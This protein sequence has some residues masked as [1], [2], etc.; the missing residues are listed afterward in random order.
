MTT[1]MPDRPLPPHRR[2][3]R[4]WEAVRG[5]L[6]ADAVFV[7][8]AA[9]L[10]FAMA[11][12]NGLVI[13]S[14]LIILVPTVTIASL[15]AAPIAIL[16]ASRMRTVRYDLGHLGMQWLTGA[17]I[18]VLTAWA[19]LTTAGPSTFGSSLPSL[20]ATIGVL[21]GIAAMIGWSWSAWLAGRKDLQSV[22]AD[23]PVDPSGARRTSEIRPMSDESA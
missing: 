1:P 22:P 17:L 10:G 18:S 8:A 14:V 16:L 4:P 19:A 15:V 23:G 5:V 9:L 3:L 6:L 21:S 7:G 2:H 20:L 13:L 11:G 12:F